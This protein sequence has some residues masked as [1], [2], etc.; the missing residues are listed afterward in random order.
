MTL[1][2]RKIALI[3]W[4]TNLHEE[5]VISQVESFRKKSLDELPKEILALLE[6]SDSAEE[7]NCIEHTNAKAILGR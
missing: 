1:E 6:M 4:I 7:T 2:Q 3:N 5:S